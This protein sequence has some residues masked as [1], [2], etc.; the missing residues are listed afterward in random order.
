MVAAAVLT[1][2]W[3]V[4]CLAQF[5]NL[6]RADELLLAGCA[7]P[8]VVGL[9]QLSYRAHFVW[10]HGGLVSPAMPGTSVAG[11]AVSTVFEIVTVLLPGC[12]FLWRNIAALTPVPPPSQP[13]VSLPASRRRRT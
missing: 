12:W 3:L 10:T 8:L 1:A 4:G 7:A 5:A 13:A 6:P 9:L 2:V 11:F